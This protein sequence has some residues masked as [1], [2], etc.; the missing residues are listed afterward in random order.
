MLW[1]IYAN[2]IVLTVASIGYFSPFFLPVVPGGPSGILIANLLLLFLVSGFFAWLIAG[3]QVVMGIIEFRAGN[4]LWKHHLASALW[5]FACYAIV[6]AL[7]S[8]GYILTA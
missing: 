6:I 5:T 8:N 1:L 2:P 7:M 4:S 3:G